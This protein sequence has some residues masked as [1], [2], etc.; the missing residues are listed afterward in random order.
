VTAPFR[1]KKK[2]TGLGLTPVRLCHQNGTHPAAVPFVV[3][4]FSMWTQTWIFVISPLAAP[5]LIRL[6][7]N[8]DEQ[9]KQTRSGGMTILT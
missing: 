8:K 3:S 1:R 4:V 5:L 9:E 6:I 7:G 2:Q